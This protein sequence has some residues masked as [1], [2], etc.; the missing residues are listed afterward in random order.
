MS[1][2]TIVALDGP[3]GG[4]S[5]FSL[6][7][8][9][10]PTGKGRPRHGQ[11]RT[12]TPRATVLAEREV[13]AAWEQAGRPRLEGPVSL[14]VELHVE[15]PRGHFTSRGELS[16]EGHR[17]PYP[18]RQ[19]PDADNAL[20][21]VMDALNTRAWRD[22]VQVVLA[23]VSRRWATRAATRVEAHEVLPTHA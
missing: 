2:T 14:T 4:P 8:D 20:K 17:H 12:W 18:E 16:A 13:R 23:L 19:K 11:G 22:D 3:D 6:T 5:A 1:A 9:G 7:I 21:L 15:R 10:K